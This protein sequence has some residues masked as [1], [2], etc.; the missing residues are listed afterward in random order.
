VNIIPEFV[1]PETGTHDE[2]LGIY[3]VVFSQEFRMIS[4]LDLVIWDY[5]TMP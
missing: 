2:G 1:W 3:G 4:N 5:G